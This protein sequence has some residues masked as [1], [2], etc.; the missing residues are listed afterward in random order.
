[1]QICC[2]LL[3]GTRIHEGHYLYCDSAFFFGDFTAWM[4]CRLPASSAH[5]SQ[6]NRHIGTW[7]TGTPSAVCKVRKR[8]LCGHRCPILKIAQVIKLAHLHFLSDCSEEQS[9]P[10]AREMQSGEIPPMLIRVGNGEI[11]LRKKFWLKNCCEPFCIL[12][13][14]KGWTLILTGGNRNNTYKCKTSAEWKAKASFSSSVMWHQEII[15]HSDSILSPGLRCLQFPWEVSFLQFHTNVMRKRSI[16]VEKM[17]AGNGKSKSAVPRHQS[18]LFLSWKCSRFCRYFSKKFAIR[19]V[20]SQ[21][22]KCSTRQGEQY[23]QRMFFV[24]FV[25]QLVFL[26]Q[27]QNL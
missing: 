2:F 6:S 17:E 15:V 8:H 20:F 11:L 27:W 4:L 19:F 5:S 21:R 24:F 12:T 14:S 25:M 1:M 7:V 9:L 3:F 22:I 10:V 13:K 16:V 18:F 26:K 23:K